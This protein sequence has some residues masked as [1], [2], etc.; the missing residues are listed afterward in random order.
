MIVMLLSSAHAITLDSSGACPGVITVDATG[1]TPSGAAYVVHAAERGDDVVPIGRCAGTPLGLAGPL[2]PVPVRADG[3]GELHVAPDIPDALCGRHVVL[4]DPATCEVSPPITLG[5]EAVVAGCTKPEAGNFDPA[6]THDDGSCLWDVTFQ[7]DLSDRLGTFTTP[8]VTGTHVDAWCGGCVPLSDP[9]GDGTYEVTIALPEGDTDYQYTLDGWAGA[10]ETL[11][12]DGSCITVFDDIYV[13]RHVTVGEGDVVLTPHTFETCPSAAV[14]VTFTLDGRCAELPAGTPYVTGT[15]DDWC[16]ACNPLS[17]VEPGLW[18]ATVDMP[19]G[20]TEYKFTVDGWDIAETLEVEAACTTTAFG[21]TN[22][23][24]RVGGDMSAPVAHWEG[25]GTCGPR[26]WDFAEDASDAVFSGDGDFVEY[27]GYRLG[28]AELVF[29]LAYVDDGVCHLPLVD[30]PAGDYRGT[31]LAS[32]DEVS[33]GRWTARMSGPTTPGTVCAFFGYDAI[34]GDEGCGYPAWVA[35]EF[36]F[37]IVDGK[38]L[39]GTYADWRPCDGFEDGAVSLYD[40]HI[41]REEYLW[42]PPP[43]FD[44]T[45][46]HEYTFDWSPEAITFFIDGVPIDTITEAVPQDDVRLMVNHWTDSFWDGF[47][48]SPPVEGCAID[49]IWGESTR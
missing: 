42:T 1:L 12:R 49:A 4:V 10:A 43:D 39:V 31:Q 23:Y 15:F 34:E 20:W 9:D 45:E 14:P 7:L 25:C 17:E 48:P 32:I 30:D 36:D 40:G 22:R 35:E 16:G 37:E 18:Q 28:M 47:P 6:A 41:A 24:L 26:A 19:A 21:Y 11:P 13:N 33:F 2:S 27:G 44:L 5:E 3:A 8:Y 46:L 38:V 29:D